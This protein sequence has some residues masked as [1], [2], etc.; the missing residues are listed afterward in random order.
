MA[1][2]TKKFINSDPFQIGGV[3]FGNDTK[4]QYVFET[5]AAGVYVNSDKA[6]AVAIAD[7]VRIG[8]LPAGAN[9]LDALMV[10]SNAFTA[11][12]TAKVGFAYVSGVDSAAVPQNDSYF[13]AAL[14]LNAQGRYPANNVAVRPVI[15]PRDAYLI[16]T[17][18][19]AALNEVGVLDVIVSTVLTGA[20]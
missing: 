19:G 5:N 8:I 2:I 6:T 1:L 13:A 16:L 11:L 10:V 7:V 20:P 9:L 12:A 18:A 3:P 15:L 14:A 17:L 4:L